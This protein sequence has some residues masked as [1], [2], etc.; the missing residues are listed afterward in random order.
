MRA[1]ECAFDW[2]ENIFTS[3]CARNITVKI[4]LL[5]PGLEIARPFSVESCQIWYEVTWLANFKVDRLLHCGNIC[6]NFVQV[7][8][9]IQLDLL[10]G[11]G[12]HELNK[13][14]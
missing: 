12:A 8:S 7:F 6:V 9:L 2:R 3:M 11:R 5:P 4:R 14:S 10:A 13:F 1:R